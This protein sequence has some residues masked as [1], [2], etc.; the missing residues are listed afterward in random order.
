MSSGSELIVTVGS[1]VAFLL[2][3]VCWSPINGGDIP[4]GYPHDVTGTVTKDPSTRY[5]RSGESGQEKV[6][7]TLSV[8]SAPSE[9]SLRPAYVDGEMMVE[10][11]S[12]RCAQIAAGER[13]AFACRGDGRMLEP[14]V[15]QCKHV[16]EVK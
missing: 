15:V 13:H 12:T 8:D 5:V 9:H 16:R 14:S 2:L 3:V 11:F 4:I 1:V 7:L 6:S 10:C